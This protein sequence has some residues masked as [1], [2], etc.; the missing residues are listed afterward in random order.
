MYFLLKLILNILNYFINIISSFYFH[1]NK[2][3]EIKLN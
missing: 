1:F 3:I 2:K